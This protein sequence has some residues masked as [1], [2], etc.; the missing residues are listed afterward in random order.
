MIGIILNDHGFIGRFDALI[1]QAKNPRAFLAVIGREL[2]NQLKTHFRLKDR[3]EPNKLGGPRSHFWNRVGQSVSNPAVDLPNRKITVSI[4]HPAFA[5]KLLGGPIVAQRVKNL[6]IPE[7]A[8]TYERSP[9]IFEQ[10]TGLKLFFIRLRSGKGGLFTRL[11]GQK[12]IQFRYLL[13]PSVN[14]LPDPTALPDMNLVAQ[15]L[16]DRGSE[17]VDRQNKAV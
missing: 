14:Q 4:T 13:T 7:D 5:Q 15:A 1:D 9:A 3:N 2:S 6:A 16:I 10:E 8:Q 12:G 11:Q 17:V